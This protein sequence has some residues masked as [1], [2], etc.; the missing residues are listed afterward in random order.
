MDAAL[1]S[2]DL[3][4]LQMIMDKFDSVSESLDV[5]ASTMEQS[6]A[7]SSSVSTPMDEVDALISQV[8][9]EHGLEMSETLDG[10]IK[11]Q[12]KKDAETAEQDELARRLEG[13]KVRH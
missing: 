12:P 13:L 9:D 11:V 8:A 1:K 6:M 7:T 4:K 2:L 5:G 3:P 10:G